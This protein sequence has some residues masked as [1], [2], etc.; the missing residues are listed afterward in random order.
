MLRLEGASLQ[1]T[2]LWAIQDALRGHRDFEATGV[3]WNAEGG[4]N[5]NNRAETK[6]IPFEI[7]P[8]HETILRISRNA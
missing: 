4:E 3:V 2:A 1:H 6:S 5:R 7:W 8:I